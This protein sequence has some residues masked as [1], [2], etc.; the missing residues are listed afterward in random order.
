MAYT[1]D[2]IKS[3]L[4]Q[5]R[6]FRGDVILLHS[7]LLDLGKMKDVAAKDAPIKVADA[8]IDY[9]GPEGTLVCP[10]FS[11]EFYRGNSYSVHDT[12]CEPWMG[13]LNENLRKRKGSTRTCHAGQSL[14]CYGKLAKKLATDD[15][16]APIVFPLPYAA[17]TVS[18]ARFDTR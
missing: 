14:V 7:S 1:Y 8:I 12:P 16:N 6:I 4:Q 18:S 5:A 9:L 2:D 10:G 11:W 13:I 15:T 3:S 17:Q